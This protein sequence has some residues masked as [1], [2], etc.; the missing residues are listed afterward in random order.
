MR[1]KTALLLTMVSTSTM[2]VIGPVDIYQEEEFSTSSRAS[3][4]SDY[5][6]YYSQGSHGVNRRGI[7]ATISPE[8]WQRRKKANKGKKHKI[9]K[10]DRARIERIAYKEALK[11]SRIGKSNV[12]VRDRYEGVEYSS[13]SNEIK[14]QALAQTMNSLWRDISYRVGKELKKI[15][16]HHS[17]DS[18][19][20]DKILGSIALPGLKKYI[21]INLP[22]ALKKNGLTSADLKD[23]LFKQGFTDEIDL[24]VNLSGTVRGASSITR[25][26]FLDE[27]VKGS[28][29]N[30]EGMS[31]E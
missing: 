22:K 15:G 19:G 7:N 4:G 20:R 23:P 18:E 27:M 8:E 9:S 25:G 31:T 13:Y 2:A 17:F 5:S 30:L 10:M 6:V 1:L 11:D 26:T 28:E 24:T 16:I 29:P 3:E 12:L 21:K 14:G